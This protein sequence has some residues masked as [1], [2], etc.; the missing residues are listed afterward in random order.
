MARDLKSFKV[1]HMVGGAQDSFP[2]TKIMV[3]P[4]GK[5]KVALRNSESFLERGSW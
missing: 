5:E 2:H 1:T 3:I 4:E